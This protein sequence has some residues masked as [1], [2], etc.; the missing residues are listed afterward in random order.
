MYHDDPKLPLLISDDI[1][2]QFVAPQ[3]RSRLSLASCL[4]GAACVLAGGALLNKVAPEQCQFDFSIVSFLAPA[5]APPTVEVFEV[6]PPVVAPLASYQVATTLFNASALADGLS[7]DWTAPAD[8]NFTGALLTMNFSAPAGA[9]AVVAELSIG[10]LPV[11]RTSTPHAALA[12][13]N[14]STTKNL[15]EYLSLFT[16]DSSIKLT[17]LEG[18]VP[19]G[20]EILLAAT[21][22]NDSLTPTAAVP[23]APGTPIEAADIF[24][25]SGAADVVVP[26]SKDGK[27]FSLP[28]D[29]FVIDLPQFSENTTVAKLALFALATEEEARWYANA[30]SAVPGD[31]TATGPVRLLNVYVDLVF[32]GAITPDPVLLTA[33]KVSANLDGSKA[34]TPLA[35]PGAFD[36]LAYELELTSVL[37]LLWA[38]ETVLTVEVVLPVKA[39]NGPG[40]QLPVPVPAPGTSA[41][42]PAAWEV[43]GNLL[44]WELAL[45]NAT[46]GVV[47]GADSELSAKATIVAPPFAGF[48]NQVV[49]S[50]LKLGVVSQLN[51]TLVSGLVQSYNVLFNTSFTALLTSTKKT[52]GA[53]TDLVVVNA[54]DYKLDFTDL[55]TGTLV[56]TLE[57]ETAYPFTLKETLG[58]A[59]PGA[60]APIASELKFDISN[61]KKTEVNGLKD[62]NF[63]Q[64]TKV[65]ITD[66]SVDTDI[67]ASLLSASQPVPFK[68]EV[69]A[70]NGVIT[71][72]TAPPV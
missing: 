2:R 47:V 62:L 28:V 69:E 14:L 22:Y 60:G 25:A 57:L 43:L 19:A 65:T 34:W 35:A 41:P 54:A 63:R 32:V 46:E 31:T 64:E 71:K 72:D 59:S 5:P 13:S 4:K 21:L 18:T 40:P 55:T 24:T 51:V 61:S 48:L 6:L 17:I 30:I 15:T 3:R 1:E 12:P 16:A 9:A 52:I 58:G 53:K 45:V 8:F 56:F 50:K 20:A 36:A 23:V 68:R 11:W 27:P 37:P 42:V 39:A 26:L 10:D 49:R 29:D 44:A 33:D 67:K 66:I 70:I 38:G 7:A